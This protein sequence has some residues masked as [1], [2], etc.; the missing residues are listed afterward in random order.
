MT[1]QAV[2]T[3]VVGPSQLKS[4]SDPKETNPR[5]SC[6]KTED[7]STRPP[8]A[9]DALGERM[10]TYEEKAYVTKLLDNTQPL[11][12]R[13]D[14]HCFHTFTKGFQRPFDENL[15]RAMVL[16][17]G[18]LVQKYQA[19]T[20]YTQSD[21]ITLV[22]DAANVE[23]KDIENDDKMKK[24][25]KEK[26]HLF[27]GRGVKI[28]SVLAGYSSARFNYHLVK[29]ANDNAFD[30]EN[31]YAPHI[32]QRVTN[33]EAHFDGRAFNVPNAAEVLNNLLWR[34]Y[35]DCTRN[36][37]SGLARKH[38]SA[39]QMHGKGKKQLLEMLKNEKNVDWAT[40]TP[41]A[42]RYGTFVK[43]ELFDM[44]YVVKGTENTKATTKRTRV[45]SISIELD[46]FDE[47]YM[48]MLLTKYWAEQW[49]DKRK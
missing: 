49:L 44:E 39:K 4:Q 13:L 19:R 26:V 1:E 32:K 36:S 20:G 42:F 27:G 23:E 7:K 46:K 38:Y 30:D 22:F 35:F 15:H 40:D 5:P 16:T 28:S 43:R 41:T 21:E 45:T 47:K 48:D 8:R 3:T 29:M 31:I 6:T 37:V 17:T 9:I 25:N 14:G 12:V 33:G 18:D 34:C 10:K 2:S 11:I 24:K